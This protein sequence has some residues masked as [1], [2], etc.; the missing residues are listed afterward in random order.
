MG[1]EPNAFEPNFTSK[2]IHPDDLAYV[3]QVHTDSLVNHQS[4]SMMF[5]YLTQMEVLNTS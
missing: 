2:Y 5:R 1:V 3:T 4:T